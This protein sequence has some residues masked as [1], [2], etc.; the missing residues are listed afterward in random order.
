MLAQKRFRTLGAG[1][2]NVKVAIVI[3]KILKD[4]RFS[5]AQRWMNWDV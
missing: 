4:R 1:V 2:L 5:P 3:W